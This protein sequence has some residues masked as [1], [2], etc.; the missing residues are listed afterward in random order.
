MPYEVTLGQPQPIN[1]GFEGDSSVDFDLGID[2]EAGEGARMTV[3][4]VEDTDSGNDPFT[5]LFGVRL[6]SLETDETKVFIFDHATARRYAPE[7]VAGEI[8]VLVLE[9]LQMLVEA[10]NPTTII[11][12]TYE[13][14]LPP[15]A[16]VKYE[17]ISK[18]LEL[19]G[20]T[21]TSY[22]RDATDLRDHWLFTK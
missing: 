6:T 13:T 5:L 11:M 10:V 21:E 22:Y 15:S 17:R 20:Y 16:M 12:G 4:L 1:Y 7:D 2:P 9:S 14:A 3:A 18:L 8:L 19:L